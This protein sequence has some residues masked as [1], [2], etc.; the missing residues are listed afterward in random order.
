MI[1]LANSTAVQADSRLGDAEL[2]LGD[3]LDHEQL[4][5]EIV[6]APEAWAGRVVTGAHSIEIEHPARWLDRDWVMLTTGALLSGD[7]TDQRR[8]IDELADA[9]IAALGFGLDVLHHQVPAG[10]IE[11]ATVRSFP[12][13]TVPHGIAFRDLV[14]LVYQA[15]LCDE[16]RAANRLAA[17]QR[18][19]I[20]SL[21][22]ESPRA[23]VVQRLAGLI[24]ST[25]GILTPHGEVTLSSKELPGPEII[26]EIGRHPGATVHFELANLHGLAFPIAPSSGEVRWLVIASPAGK[27]LHPLAK[28]A[29]RTTVPLLAA[30]VRLEHVQQSEDA[31]VRRA[32]LEALLDLEDKRDAA[33]VAARASGSGLDLTAGATVIVIEDTAPDA[34]PDS[35]IPAI[36]ASLDGAQIPAMATVRDGRIVLIVAHRSRAG[37][38]AELIASLR[39]TLRVGVGRRVTEPLA[40][41]QSY[42]DALLAVRARTRGPRQR[43]NVI[44]YDDLDVGTVLVHE[45]PLERLAPKIEQWLAPLLENPLAYEALVA[46]LRYDLDVGRTARALHLHPNSVR[47]RLARAEE[48]LGVHLRSSETIVALHVALLAAGSD[49]R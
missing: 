20:D 25:V 36:G 6:V 21:G 48:L 47:Y 38:A 40:V 23:T 18:F 16:I 43:G 44:Q 29:G 7:L 32:T 5:L 2:T 49:P 33:I 15:T 46:Y 27:P 35:L 8:L 28:T 9:G 19:L 45:A 11:Q 22:E 14:G 31:A 34:Q 42:A 3:L 37:A 1:G 17:M 30:L 41:R 13:F 39:E 26:A 24:D 12:V 10:L 4:G